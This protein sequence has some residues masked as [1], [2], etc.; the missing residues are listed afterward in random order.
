MHDEKR[1]QQ[2]AWLEP[3]FSKF[4]ENSDISLSQKSADKEPAMGFLLQI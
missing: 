1:A 4:V 3:R 2:P